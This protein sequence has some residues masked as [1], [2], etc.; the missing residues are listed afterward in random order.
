MFPSFLSRVIESYFIY[1]TSSPLMIGMGLMTVGLLVRL[2]LK[3]YSTT[4]VPVIVQHEPSFN[5]SRLLSFGHGEAYR[6]MEIKET[7]HH[8]TIFTVY[9]KAYICTVC[10]RGTFTFLVQYYNL[11]VLLEMNLK[12]VY[13][14]DNNISRKLLMIFSFHT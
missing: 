5:N 14:V 11:K 9:R 12:D 1:L 7:L 8:Y 2:S 6:S 10:T 3:V 4:S 13:F